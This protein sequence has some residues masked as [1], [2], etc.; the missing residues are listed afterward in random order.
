MGLKASWKVY[1]DFQEEKLFVAPVWL[2]NCCESY[3]KGVL[4]KICK[5]VMIFL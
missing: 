3:V 4:G 1:A 5:K 2:W